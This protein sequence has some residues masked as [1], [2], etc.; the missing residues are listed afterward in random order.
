MNLLTANDRRGAYPASWYAA[1]AAPHAPFPA[2]EG[3]TR[4]DVC[5]VGAGFTG[6]SA[7]LHLAQR[8]FDVVLL[9]AHRVGFGASGR[10]GGQV[11]SGQR[12]EQ[13]AL[14]DLVGRDDARRLWDMAEDAKALVG[15]L[16]DTHA[17]ACTFHPG[18]AHACWRPREVARAHAYA[19][20]LARDYGYDRIEPLDRAG[21]AALTGSDAYAGG[22]IDHGAGHIHPLNFALGLA[23]A[24]ARAGVRLHELSEVTDIAPGPPHRV[25]LARAEVTA[26]HVLLACNGYLGR[27]DRQVAARV[28]P[29][30][31][32][33]VA[34]EPLGER[35][36]AI[37][38]TNPAVA[39]YRNSSSTTGAGPRTGGCSSAAAR[40][41]ATASRATS[42][43][44]CASRCSRSTPSSPR[45]ASTMPGAGRW[46][47]P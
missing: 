6:L 15:T 24:A 17:M 37:L 18:V 36:S 46:R 38:P 1:T 39:R 40:A 20:K 7:A 2:L 11:G 8:G 29:I 26:D 21:I 22:E 10:N 47:S 9:D 23:A 28:M 16:I 13:D 12:L 41:T 33:V 4:A 32:F 19:D 43:R 45:P 44:W 25:T 34:T 3:A 42:P 30:N 35:W 27:L 31:N 5:V 14:E